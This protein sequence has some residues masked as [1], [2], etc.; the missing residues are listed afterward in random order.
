MGY[1]SLIE[2]LR[3]PKNLSDRGI[4]FIKGSGREE[5][6]SYQ[7][8]YHSALRALSY[9]QIKAVK[10]ND[11]LIFQVDDNRTFIVVFWAC[12]LG[13][14]IPVPLSFGHNDDHRKKLFNVWSVLANPYT[15][16]SRNNLNKLREFSEQQGLGSLYSRISNRVVDE[17]DA[18]ASVSEGRIADVTE[19]NIALIQFS[20]GSTGNPKG[21]VLTHKNLITNIESISQASSYSTTDSMM[22]W[23]PLTHDMGLIGFHINP[24]FCGMNQYLID[25]NLFIRRPSLWLAKASE[26]KASILCSPNFGY[27]Y[28]IKHDNA[29]EPHDWDLSHVRIVYNGAEPI[30][31]KLCC[32]FLNRLKQYGLKSNAMCP[33]YGLA[34]ASLAVSIS[35]MDDE[36]ISISLD[37]NKLNTGDEVAIADEGSISFVN[38]G[39]SIPGCSIRI[40]DGEDVAYGDKVVGH[41]QIKG[42]NVTAGYYKD[43][44]ETARVI[45]GAG[46]LKTGDLGFTVDG[47]LYVT[48]RAK[49][50]I[51]TNGRNY[52][53]HDLE[54][55][56]E[57]IEGIEL[58]KIVVAG[59]F[60]H[61]T[62]RE[63]VMAFVFHRAGLETFK[64]VE[65]SLKELVNVKTGI[66]IDRIIPVKD[67][68]RT[69]SGKLQRFKLV[70]QYKNGYFKEVEAELTKIS[71]G[72]QR[73]P[74]LLAGPGNQTE[75]KLL[76]IWKKALDNGTVGVTDRF[77]EIG[78]NSLKA[79]EIG[80][81]VLK[82]FQVELP[83][84]ILYEKQSIRELANEINSLKKLKYDGLPLI[85]KN[86]YYPLAPSQ[87]RL[88]YLWE[89]DRS[90]IAYNIPAAFRIT[91]EIDTSWLTH[92]IRQIIERHDSLRMSFYMISEPKFKVHDNIDFTL[93]CITCSPADV[94]K[95]LKRLVTPFDLTNGPLFR[96]SLLKTGTSESIL[97]ADFHHIISDGISVY[98]FIDELLNLYN[99][100]TLPELP[101]QY[102]D[103]VYWQKD[104]LRPD[105]L[106][107]QEN[108]WSK[109][110]EGELPILKMPVD[111]Q[112]PVIFSNA[113]EKIEFGF[114][115]EVTARLRNIAKEQ[116]CTLHAVLFAA[117]NIL[118]SKYSGQDDII[119]G[120]PVAARRHPDIQKLQG[121]FV[122]NLAIRSTVAGDE[123]FTK[124]LETAQRTIAAALDNQDY[125][126]EELVKKV[127][128]E[129]E[130]SRNPVFD[131]M[132]VYQNMGLSKIESPDIK[133]S[134]YFF[135]PGFSKFDISMEIFEEGESVKY[136]IEY[137]T[138]LFRRET[139]L[140]MAGHFDNLIKGIIDNP[141]GE[142]SDLTLINDSEFH[143]YVRKF[144]AT[145]YFYPE[146]KTI[147][148]LFEEQVKR[149]PDSVAFEYNGTKETYDQLNRK[150]NYLAGVLRE[151]GI[152]PNS[153][154]GILLP[155]TPELVVGILG[156]LKAGGCYLL[157]DKDLPEERINYLISNS[158]CKVVI[159]LD[160]LINRSNVSLRTEILDIG[161]LE[162]MSPGTYELENIASTGDL[163][164]IVYTSGTTGQP[165]GVMI[166]HRSLTNYITWAAENYIKEEKVAFPLYTSVSFDLT[167]TSI[168]TPLITG[169]SI[170]IYNEEQNELLIE[171]IVKDSKVD[172]IKLTPSHLKI[173]AESSAVNKRIRRFI[174]GGEQLETRLAKGIVDKFQGNVEI[175]NEYGP[176]E[177]TVGCM[178]HKFDPE[179]PGLAVPIG[180]PIGNTQ[181]YIL[182]KF[183]KPVPVGVNGEVYISGE[184]VA[185]GYLFN[186]EVTK[187]KFIPDP[188]I[189][190]QR[191]Y[192]T[193]DT[194][195]RLTNGLIEYIGRSDQQVKING[196]RIELAEIE[197]QLLRYPGITETL[198]AVRTNEKGKKNL[199][200]YYKSNSIMGEAALR[201]HLAN[202]LPHYMIPM[203]FI[204]IERIPLTGNGK[205]DY[206]AI[207]D[208]EAGLEV[209]KNTLP[210]NEI[211][212]LSLEVW[213]EVLGV[214]DLSIY[215]NFFEL[216]GDSIIAVQ[217]ASRLFEKGIALSA[218]D[219][220]IYHT[221]EQVS[222]HAKIV[223]GNNSY[224]QGVI[225]GEVQ[226]KPVD[227]WFF[228]QHFENPNYYNQSVLLTF[229]KKVSIRQLEQAF[230]K[231]IEHHD[232]LRLNYD[233]K[234]SVLFY[235][236]KHVG[237]D[238]TI[239]A[240]ET[241]T[242]EDAFSDLREICRSLNK[243]FDITDG[244]LLKA[245]MIR[246]NNASEMLFI[247]A[248]HLVVDGV[249][250]RVLLEDL[251]AVYNALERRE[252]VK[253]PKKT[254]SLIDWSARL[255]EYS[256]SAELKMEDEYWREVDSAEFSIP[257]D[258]A[259]DEW[260]VR[261]LSRMSGALNEERTEFL[262]KEAHG[263]YKTDVLI[264]LNIALALALR[265]WT[266]EDTLIIEQESY[267]RQLESVNTSRT[268]GWFT[269]MY[270][271][272][273][274]LKQDSI[275]NQIKDI[276]EQI[277][278]V[279]YSGIGYGVRK[280]LG[281]PGGS[282][283]T[284]LT[285]IRL[286][287]L[288]Q[289]D[290]EL[291]NELFSFNNERHAED[292][293]PGNL[294]TAKL[295]FNLMVIYGKLNLDINF[296]RKAHNVS[297]I[298]SLKDM[299]FN[300]LELILEH[301]EN[302]DDIHFTPSDFDGVDLDDEELHA[303]F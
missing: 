3:E 69:T 81:A 139:I 74:D 170:V 251:K 114:S 63:E 269:A 249:S 27:Q 219:I 31:L 214:P 90:S 112:R 222:L 197:A 148:Q 239:E 267:G 263:T 32:D 50:I 187:R 195:R 223:D 53:P 33:V 28:F 58:N 280:Y 256:G 110:L 123:S 92:S 19:N 248:H 88:Y 285:E 205:V 151:K 296:N 77:F 24:L 156:V 46:W 11:E 192:A 2:I 26:H 243:R 171:K 127:S 10:P 134:R 41:I 274:E 203:R 206:S 101:A 295:E 190:G 75:Q 289:F 273:L 126:F 279:P 113:G 37:R 241:R 253:L 217:I 45:N 277:R 174:V 133:L 300:N 136:N 5:F 183:L 79:A 82:E 230:A 163:A 185:K 272:K 236:K 38:V 120:I 266:G 235:N 240:F 275:S 270:P 196:Y 238:F 147:H 21:V 155:R 177:A 154:V 98:N 228:D 20:S 191:M 149:T 83:F 39:R 93:S 22:S 128:K 199:Y 105:E 122:N 287:Y 96:I 178:I 233:P 29:S 118:I 67:I 142:V 208:P 232:G 107:R 221:I 218:K 229:H 18:L 173:L 56:A 262:L 70:E 51:F 35:G 103:F 8:L 179:D 209:K 204:R 66:V 137:S 68:P 226:L 284:K 260:K 210:K 141:A 125:P 216:G 301:I 78:G 4:T 131:S 242:G 176:T 91:G 132:F 121:M 255:M 198:I 215:D 231:V 109:E 55:V 117:Y 278:R 268:V 124:F 200:A 212:A 62:E 143:E 168:F 153:I 237:S 95:E 119:I 30:S 283:R 72:S 57:E 49:D 99:G 42:D 181:I 164:Y 189:E 80:M 184:G 34:E 144:N 146:T 250:W 47:A 150:S 213:R 276:K 258:F 94:D 108:H 297:T 52:F 54:K 167:F 73:D 140:R 6:L 245:A 166:G 259:I 160:E 186:E 299:F 252:P 254:A 261:Y 25:T 152:V 227:S 40:T 115:T 211:E 247:T 1:S 86:D 257:Q 180:I 271:I 159:T 172:I 111:F 175:F 220:L 294:M 207:P 225:D 281:K 76:A 48:G 157:I 84:E 165:K 188:F 193:G 290:K 291:N 9:L 293:D 17:D 286:N 60:N 44:H 161:E 201:D 102:R 7:E 64:P 15:I 162:L 298:R 138:E 244:L 202:K 87:K 145:R 13:G 116:N 158:Q 302:E 61:Q 65:K 106:K 288:G 14:I 135:D 264:L 100:K 16:I 234:K 36:V 97:F 169:N 89:L 265:E 85:R 59:F 104:Y 282:D 303:L 292:I 23:M 224:D 130:V 246:L 129:R 43:E 71:E 12:I 194:A 182:D